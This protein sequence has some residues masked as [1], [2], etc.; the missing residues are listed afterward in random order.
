[1][2]KFVFRNIFLGDVVSTK[3]SGI[4]YNQSKNYNNDSKPMNTDF[5]YDFFDDIS[6]N[7]PVGYSY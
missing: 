4:N 3:T 7:S 5:W 2:Y 1:M 6:D